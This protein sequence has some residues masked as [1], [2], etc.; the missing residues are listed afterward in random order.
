MAISKDDLKTI[1]LWAVIPFAVMQIGVSPDYWPNFTEKSWGVH[2]HFWTASAWFIFLI[3]QAW[4]IGQGSMHRH[5]TWGIIGFFIAGGVIFSSLALYPNDI[6]TANSLE[7]ANRV[8]GY[9]SAQ[10]FTSLLIAETLLIAAF[11]YAIIKSIIERKNLQEHAWWLLC[12]TYFIMMPTVGRGMYYVSAFFVGGESN[13]KAW[14][15]ELPSS[16]LIS[17]LAMIMVLRFKKWKHWAS[18]LAI[19]L[20]PI[21]YIVWNMAS[22]SMVIHEWIKSVIVVD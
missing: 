2:I 20:T 11:A 5:R 14:H 12:S 18:W 16:I 21:S 4:L 9:L 22:S 10:S 13:L 3:M 7:A 8:I 15:V 6:R 1:Y 17:G 19:L